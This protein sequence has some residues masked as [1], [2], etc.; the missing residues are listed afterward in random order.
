MH[1]LSKNKQ[2]LM[3]YV[4]L[5][6]ATLVVFWQVNSCDFNNYDDTFYVTENSHI[7]NGITLEGIRWAFTTN[8]VENWHPLT[9]ISHMLDVQ[10]FGLNPRWHHLTNLLFHS[11]NIVLLFFVLHRMTRSRWESAF[12]AALFAL[13]P[14]HVESVAWV[15]ERKDVLSAFFWILTMIAYCYY[16]DH[17]RLQRYLIVV[18][19]FGLG[20]MAKPMLV[21]LPFVLLLLDYWPLQRFRHKSSNQKSGTTINS[22]FSGDKQKGKSGKKYMAREEVKAEIPAG[23]T[24]QWKLIRPLLGEKIPL[25]VLAAMSSIVTYI[26]QQKGGAVASFEAIPL[27]VRI[28]NAF[29]SYFTY[30]EKTIWPNDLA[31]LYPYPLSLPTWQVFGAVLL[32]TVV[33]V[34]VTVKARKVPYLV[35]GWLWYIGTLVPVIGIVQVGLQ[36]RA[37]RYTYIP[38]IGLF[39]MVT[40]GISEL[41]AKWRY[42]KEALFALSIGLLLCFC[43]IT[44]TQVGYWQSSITLFGRAAN[45]TDNNY[46]AYYNRGTAYRRLGDYVQAIRDYDK[47]IAINPKYVEAYVNRGVAY[48]HL[49]NYGQ[50]IGDFNKAIEKIGRAHV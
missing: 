1:S 5:T 2:I 26:V 14:L 7:Q 4:F 44:R 49:G 40:W 18:V 33:T 41:S 22:H 34:M 27:G 28:S 30:I 38:L 47:T 19:F 42:R 31:V 35:V 45:V 25:F 37:D 15:A 20:L 8:Y 29:V 6:I 43:M 39:I 24:Y 11:A 3:I 36:A 50:A 48:S 13:H 16:V 32:M 9:W 23:S 17:P 12:V 21:T 46:T 10:F